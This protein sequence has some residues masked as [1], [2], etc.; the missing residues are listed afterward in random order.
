MKSI[1]GPAF[2]ISGKCASFW[3]LLD[4][5]LCAS[6]HSH[7][8][9]SPSVL[10]HSPVSFLRVGRPVQSPRHCNITDTHHW[11]HLQF[12]P[13]EWVALRVGYYSQENRSLKQ[14]SSLER[15]KNKQK[16]LSSQGSKKEKNTRIQQSKSCLRHCPELS[17]GKSSYGCNTALRTGERTA[18][19]RE[20]VRRH[21][22][23]TPMLFYQVWIQATHSECLTLQWPQ[24]LTNL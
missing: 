22:L 13:K 14:L 23:T 2:S 9:M 12:L 4:S 24:W 7:R 3:Q 18:Q 21:H 5:S 16:T 17:Q 10:W 20:G 6:S 1:S 8:S 15:G 11:F 19:E